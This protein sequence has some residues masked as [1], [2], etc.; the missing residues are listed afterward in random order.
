M[1]EGGA[2]MGM[3]NFCAIHLLC[4]VLARLSPTTDGM[5]QDWLRGFVPLELLMTLFMSGKQREK[6][7]RS[8]VR[9]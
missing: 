1:D 9:A 5:Y 3:K 8:G 4:R 7:I 2:G 6:M